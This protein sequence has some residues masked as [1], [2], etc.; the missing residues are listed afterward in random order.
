MHLYILEYTD[1]HYSFTIEVLYCG[2]HNTVTR[3][4]NNSRLLL[5]QLLMNWPFDSLH[6]HGYQLIWVESLCWFSLRVRP[7]WASSS[8]GLFLL[9]QQS[10]HDDEQAEEAAEFAQEHKHTQVQTEY[11][12]AERVQGHLLGHVFFGFIFLHLFFLCFVSLFPSVLIAAFSFFLP[13]GVLYLSLWSWVLY[14]FV[15][16]SH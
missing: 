16:I 3:R 14:V 6:S 15:L 4:K 9:S 12:C 11:T 13:A 10:R 1:K 7:L 8:A 2:V 5:R